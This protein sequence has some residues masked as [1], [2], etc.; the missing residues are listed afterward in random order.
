MNVPRGTSP[1]AGRT[2]RISA[3]VPLIKK[4]KLADL[5]A[6]L[7]K[8]GLAVS[9]TE[10]VEFAIDDVVDVQALEPDELAERIMTWRSNGGTR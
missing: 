5:A 1:E 6:V 9:Q 3:R 4:T 2:E 8:R 10:L 7:T